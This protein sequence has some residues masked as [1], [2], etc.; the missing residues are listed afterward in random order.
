[1]T[2]VK[3]CGVSRPADI[4]AARNAGADAVGLVLA[5]SPRRVDAERAKDLAAAAG[6]LEVILLTVDA[7]A[8]Q[9]LDLAQ[10][11]GATG[12]QPYGD[13]SAL[14]AAACRQA[15]LVVL[16]PTTVRDEVDLTDI[17]LDQ[18]PLLDAHD[19]EKFGGT[20]RAVDRSLLQGVDRDFVLAGG[21]R[22][23]NIADAIAEV[24]PWGVDASSGLESAPGI[25]DPELIHA[26]VQ[27]A[28]RT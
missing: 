13:Y 11:V 27:E 3:V 7:T 5:E 16:R 26:Y 15:G 21:L 8:S 12:V 22:P 6:D 2:W 4:E 25:K 14:A 10:H 28:K 17:P 24:R 9:L 23:D 18:I 1:M 19:P 20:G